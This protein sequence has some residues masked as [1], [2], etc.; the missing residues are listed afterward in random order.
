MGRYDV[1]STDYTSYAIVYSCSPF[2]AGAFC[3]EYVWV[4]SRLP[5]Q[6]GT[7]A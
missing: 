3:L 6:N 7:D 4:L 2:L 1:V 5:Y